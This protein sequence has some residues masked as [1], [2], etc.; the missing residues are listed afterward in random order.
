MKALANT[1]VR[2]SP[3]DRVTLFSDTFALAQ[4]GRVPMASYFALLAAI[5]KVDAIDRATLFSMASD[6]LTFLDQAM[7]GTPAQGKIRAAGRLLFAPELSRLGWVPGAEEDSETLKL[8]GLLISQLA[9]FN[10]RSTIERARQL[11]DLDDSGSSAIQ[12][13]PETAE[14]GRQRRGPV[15][16]RSRAGGRAKRRPRARIA[17]GFACRHCRAQYRL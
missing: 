2:L 11:F 12:S 16:I 7:A 9:R 4:A 6:D 1:F 15:D 17:V 5:P 13:T 14:G 8:R 3:A 10:D